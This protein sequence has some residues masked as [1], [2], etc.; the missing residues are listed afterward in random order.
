[1]KTLNKTTNKTKEKTK[2]VIEK[3]FVGVIGKILVIPTAIGYYFTNNVFL[4]LLLLLVLF[5][6][7]RLNFH[8]FRL[9][10]V[11]RKPKVMKNSKV[12]YINSLAKE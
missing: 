6:C 1:M 7:V 2:E 8:G 11:I 10:Q 4:Q 3:L 5:I 12:I 9:M